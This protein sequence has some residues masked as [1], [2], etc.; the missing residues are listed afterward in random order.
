[1]VIDCIQCDTKYDLGDGLFQEAIEKGIRMHC[2]YCGFTCDVR[3]IPPSL[4]GD[5]GTDKPDFQ[6]AG[7][8]SV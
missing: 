8:P 2:S 5:E 6:I 4:Q 1:M 7:C 3:I